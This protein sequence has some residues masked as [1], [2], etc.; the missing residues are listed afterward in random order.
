MMRAQEAG[1]SIVLQNSDLP[2]IQPIQ[3]LNYL[4]IVVFMILWKLNSLHSD[5]FLQCFNYLLSVSYV[6]I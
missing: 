3:T 6:A 1:E 5:I 4:R 2:F